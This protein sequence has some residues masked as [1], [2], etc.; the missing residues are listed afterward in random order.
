MA[1]SSS[2]VLLILHNHRIN[3][4]DSYKGFYFI[5]TTLSFITSILVFSYISSTSKLFIHHHHHHP[6]QRDYVAAG[7]ASSVV[8]NVEYDNFSSSPP[9]AAAAVVWELVANGGGGESSSTQ[10]KTT[11]E[12]DDVDDDEEASMKSQWQSG[13][14]QLENEGE[15]VENKDVFHDR[16]L[17]LEDYKDMNKTL[18]IYVYPHNKNDPFANVLL[19]EKNEPR[20][21]YASESYFKK[22]LFKSHFLTKNPYEANLFYLPFSIAG[23]RNDKRISVDGIPNFIRNYIFNISR[24]YPFW[25][26]TNGADHFYVACHSV[27]RSAMAKVVEA[28]L[29]AIQVVCSSSYFIQGY[30]SHKDAS[31]PQIW[32]RKGEPPNQPPSK[33]KKL[34]FYAGAMNSPVRQ[35]LVK[36]WGNDSEM[37]IHRSRLKTPYSEALLGSKFCIHA[38]GFEVNTA[39]IGDALYYGCVPV[40]LADYYDLPF[41]DILNWKSFSLVVSTMD[42]P[43][44]KKMLQQIIN[45]G[46]YLRLYHN[47]IQVQKHF[48]WYDKP[49]DYDVFHMVMYELWIRRSH[50]RVVE[51]IN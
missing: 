28:K 44:L 45:S 47:V 42:I 5:I 20:G 18:K 8:V 29:N 32:P 41:A 40:I 38:K 37:S 13:I 16:T 24:R 2:S 23:L 49:I 33:R 36:E 26:R 3:N 17:F 1:R 10:M 51:V 34:A 31:I 4:F 15:N 22:S 39:R 14:F 6:H 30:V 7:R 12:K 9:A 46:D 50:A 35:F 27:G 25:N 43:I 48:Q 21:N 11:S 19:Q